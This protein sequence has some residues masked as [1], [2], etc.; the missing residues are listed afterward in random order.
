MRKTR[1]FLLGEPSGVRFVHVV[2]RTAGQHILFE[3]QLKELFGS[4]LSRQLR[5]S[6]LR[7][8]AWCFMGN[9]FHLL[10]EIPDKDAALQGWTPQ[11]F[12]QRLSPLQGE[13]STRLLLAEIDFHRHH[14]NDKALE[15]I[16]QRIRARLFD[17]S[18]FMKEL[19]LKLSAACNL[20]Q[21]RSGALWDGRYKSLLVEGSAQAL[22]AVAAYIDLNPV[23]A[24]L[25]EEPEQYRWS[26]YGAAVAGVKSAR[27][28]LVRALSGGGEEGG[29]R[30]WGAAVA[31]YRMLL[32][33]A[34]DEDPGGQPP[35]G[36]GVPGRG[37]PRP[38]RIREVREAGGRLRVAEALRCRVRYFTDGAVLGS[39]EFVDGFFEGRR[40]WFGERRRDGARRMRGAE[41]GELRVL[42]DL[43]KNRMRLPGTGSSE[44]NSR[45]SNREFRSSEIPRPGFPP[46]SRPQK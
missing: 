34:G 10:L 17:L 42:R 1:S 46:R 13:L 15:A 23:R 19:K 43:K 21:G 11:D 8:L 44:P 9:H 29:K 25:V 22:S 27:A 41:W 16:A 6:G 32:Y 26:S 35:P 39:A 2:S 37:G 14:G 28:G 33:G 40:E 4:I 3:D 45:L 18:M 31:E 36:A 12:F 20:A 30:R 5:F 38:E 7:S 24:G